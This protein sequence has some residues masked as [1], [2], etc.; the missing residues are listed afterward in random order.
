MSTWIK[1]ILKNGGNLILKEGSINF[2]AMKV[3]QYFNRHMRRVKN[4]FVIVW[5]LNKKQKCVLKMQEKWGP[6]RGLNMRKRGVIVELSSWTKDRWYL[7]CL[8]LSTIGRW[9]SKRDVVI[10][11][12]QMSVENLLHLTWNYFFKHWFKKLYFVTKIVLT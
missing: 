5:S 12:P 6:Y 9:W 8:R 4:V 7:N 2:L 3:S 10:E 1:K 11:W